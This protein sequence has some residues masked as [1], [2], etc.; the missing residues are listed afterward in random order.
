MDADV[1]DGILQRTLR[2]TH[3]PSSCLVLPASAGCLIVALGY[4]SFSGRAYAYLPVFTEKVLASE[5][6]AVELVSRNT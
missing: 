3:A 2:Q 6:N 1:K 4:S 5:K